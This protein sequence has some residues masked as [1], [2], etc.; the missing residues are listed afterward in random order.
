MENYNSWALRKPPS[1]VK[2]MIKFA[3]GSRKVG[4]R[5]SFGYVHDEDSKIVAE[6]V[7]VPFAWKKIEKDE[8]GNYL[9]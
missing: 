2:V 8:W 9:W 6:D 1:N 3:D 7:C 5:D 4:Y